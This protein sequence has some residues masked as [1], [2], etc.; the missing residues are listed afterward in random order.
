MRHPLKAVLDWLR[1]GYP[2]GIP[3]KD[4]FA[5]LALLR[6]R[7]SDDEI[8]QVV[9]LSVEH[10]HET[11]DRHIDYERV[12]ELIAG[13]MGE[14]PSEEDIERVTRRLSEV[15]WPLTTSESHDGDDDDGAADSTS[16]E[17]LPK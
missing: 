8:D 9:A 6:R 16:S 17:A 1:S 13:T 7:L 2:E 12:R 10:A 14:E 3:E 5:V 11:P 4:H 15:D